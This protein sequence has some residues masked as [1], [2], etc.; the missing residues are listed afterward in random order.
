M[1]FSMLKIVLFWRGLNLKERAIKER[2][3]RQGETFQIQT[4]T[5]ENGFTVLIER[6]SCYMTKGKEPS[7][8]SFEQWDGQT[9]CREFKNS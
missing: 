1:S 3:F 5:C 4:R 9:P 2:V 7:G 6:C 8:Q